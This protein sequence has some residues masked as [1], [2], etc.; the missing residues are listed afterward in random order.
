MSLSTP[1]AFIIFNRPDLTKIVFEAIAKVKPE[2]LFVVADGPRFPEEVEKCEEARAIIERVDWDCEVF[3]NFSEKNLGCGRREASGFD[4][5]FSE[6]E[7]AIFLEDDI[8]PTE[9][10]FSFCQTLLDYYRDDERIMTI[11][12]GN[13]QNGKSRTDYSYYF[14]KYIGTWGWASWRR[15]WKHYDYDMKTWPEYKKAGMMKFVCEYPHEQR[16]WT[17]LFDR[18]YKDPGKIDTWDYQW[19]YACWSQ[20]G[21]GIEPNLNLVSNIGCG[22]LDAAHMTGDSPLAAL[23]TTDICE[24]MHPQ[25][26]VRHRDADKYMFD[27]HFPWNKT[28]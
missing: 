23:P 16:Y 24:I 26:V 28:P 12:G 4:W 5:V 15:A 7:E 2:K 21:L 25:F 19:I 11:G 20:N 6:V 9:T 22:R 17:A 27:H 13:Y 10:F 8:L 1:V 3:T 14:S 18:M